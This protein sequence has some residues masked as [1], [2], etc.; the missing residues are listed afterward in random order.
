MEARGSD[1]VS[2]FLSPPALPNVARWCLVSLL[3]PLFLQF[4]GC[5]CIIQLPRSLGSIHHC[6]AAAGWAVL[7]WS[8][9]PSMVGESGRQISRRGGAEG[10]AGRL[11][12]VTGV[13]ANA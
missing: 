1:V 10:W 7:L 6:V 11:T 3:L 8:W 2:L 13:H 4:Y 12:Q 5:M 9:T